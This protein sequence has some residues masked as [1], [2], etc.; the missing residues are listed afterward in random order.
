MCEIHFIYP[1]N[2]KIQKY[3]VNQLSTLLELGAF[4]NKDG[5]GV[6]D[7]K[8]VYKSEKKYRGKYKKTLLANFEK[9][10]FLLAHNR[11]GTSGVVKSRNA[12]PFYNDRFIWVHNGHIWNHEIL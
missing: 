12:H 3:D 11:F 5:Y 7:D 6:C 4:N 1:I 9:S 2:G 8:L 10:S